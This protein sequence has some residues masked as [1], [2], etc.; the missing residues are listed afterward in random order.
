MTTCFRSDSVSIRRMARAAQTRHF[1]PVVRNAVHDQRMVKF[2]LWRKCGKLSDRA[3]VDGQI[4]GLP[5]VAVESQSFQLA[6]ATRL[7]G[8]H[9]R[10]VGD[11][12]RGPF[13]S[14]RDLGAQ[15]HRDQRVVDAMDDLAGQGDTGE[16]GA[17]VGGGL[18]H[19]TAVN[20][21]KA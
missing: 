12:S 1:G 20:I 6:L 11:D 19:D 3:L 13:R 15:F 16:I 7:G 17:P 2:D 21:E 9:E 18:F 5:F 14:M 10:A 4:A 8:E